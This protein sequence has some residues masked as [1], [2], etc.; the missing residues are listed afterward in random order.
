VTPTLIRN[1]DWVI[2][3]DEIAGHHVYRRNLDIAFADGTI[4]FVGRNYP[5]VADRVIDGGDRLVLPGLINIHSH[6]RTSRFIAACA[7]ST[8]CAI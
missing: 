5:G 8:A 6:P 7:R 3:W 1:A 2:A 4:I